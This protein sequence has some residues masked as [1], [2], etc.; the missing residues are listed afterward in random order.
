[1]CSPTVTPNIILHVHVCMV[2]KYVCMVYVC[3][4]CLNVEPA[5]LPKNIQRAHCIHR[6]IVSI[7]YM[8]PC[9]IF[10]KTYTRYVLVYRYYTSSLIAV[11]NY[12]SIKCD[13]FQVF[14]VRR[15]NG[16]AGHKYCII[17][18]TYS[19]TT[20]VP[21]F[22]GLSNRETAVRMYD[23]ICVTTTSWSILITMS[24]FYL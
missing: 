16:P 21:R 5:F 10:P 24:I 2:Y 11:T 19:R 13:N 18:S 7:Y 4:C 17:P 6:F 14:N 15:R 22:D 9:W 3:M 12:E 23:M 20:T 1:M 8:C